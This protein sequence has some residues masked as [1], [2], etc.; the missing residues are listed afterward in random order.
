MKT[1]EM[2][3]M[4]KTM[5]ELTVESPNVN[6]GHDPA[7]R[8]IPES[9]REVEALLSAYGEDFDESEGVSPDSPKRSPFHSH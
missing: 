9:D 4:T 7:S 6:L 1:M 3:M 5:L 2:R 8:E